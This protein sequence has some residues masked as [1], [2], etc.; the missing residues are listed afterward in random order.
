MIF[1]VISAVIL[2]IITT[3]IFS[4]KKLEYQTQVGII[5]STGKNTAFWAVSNQN[6][7]ISNNPNSEFIRSGLFVPYDSSRNKKLDVSAGLDLVRRFDGG[8]DILYQQYYLKFKYRF[9][10]LQGGRI[11]EFFGNQDST[12]SSG[13]LLYSN[14]AQ[15]LPKITAGILNYTAIPF[16]N[17]LVE[18][19]GAVS[20]GWFEKGTYVKDTWLHQKYMFVRFGGKW[21]VRVHFGLMHSVQWSGISSDPSLGQLPSSFFYYTVIFQA[22]QLPFDSA[23]FVNRGKQWTEYY[24]RI[25]NHLGS[26][27][28]GIDFDIN[29]TSISLY[30]QNIMEDAGGVNDHNLRDGMLG[31]KIKM[32]DFT[33]VNKIVFEFINTTDQSMSWPRKRS[34]REPDDYFYNGIYQNGWTY[35]GNIIG[36][37]LITSPNLMK[38]IDP[39]SGIRI[40]NNRVIAGHFGVEG[41]VLN[42]SYRF[43]S[44]Y[45][46]NKGQWNLNIPPLHNENLS[47]MLELRKNLNKFYNIDI[48]VILAADFGKMYN[49][50]GT[51]MITLAK[52]G[53][54][55]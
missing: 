8:Y 54:L 45:S 19:K 47:T 4:Q 36:T 32:N 10:H 33:K 42:M 55:F 46:V 44:T 40:I 31:L 49:N 43:L 39:N 37:P 53:K 6:G 30:Y 7:V 28:Y 21:P 52:R 12:L 1:R 24:N 27:Y 25:G 5:S 41:N 9:L 3:N 50:N 14:N 22:K 11:E 23:D 20:H 35:K 38:M 16:T 2:I 34:I 29:K 17:G 26:K 48:S 51:L 15:P 13:C 18:I